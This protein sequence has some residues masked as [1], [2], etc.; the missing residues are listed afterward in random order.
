MACVAGVRV[1]RRRPRAQVAQL[2]L[3]AEQHVGAT[4]A[5]RSRRRCS[6]VIS[7]YCARA[8]T[9]PG[10]VRAAGGLL[11][12]LHAHGICSSLN[13]F[14]V[15]RDESS[16]VKYSRSVGS[17]RL[18]YAFAAAGVRAQSNCTSPAAACKGRNMYKLKQESRKIRQ[19]LRPPFL[20][21]GD[22]LRESPDAPVAGAHRGRAV[23][24]PTA[25]GRRPQHP[26]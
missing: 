15:T 26:A 19:R 3:G 12:S 4:P 11:Q 7:N 22:G 16:V 8:C 17:R 2:A 1:R 21:R 14:L 20:R 9:N 10:A 5:C 25:L 13:C 24:A 18:S 23:A 6:P